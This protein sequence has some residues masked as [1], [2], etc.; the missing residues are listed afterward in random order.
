MLHVTLAS[1]LSLPFWR[2]TAL[3]ISGLLAALAGT[4]YGGLYAIVNYDDVLKPNWS[5]L[6][7][8]AAVIGGVDSTLGSIIGAALIVLANTFFSGTFGAGYNQ[9]AYGVLL[10]LVLLFMPGGLISPFRV[11]INKVLRKLGQNKS[12]PEAYYAGS[13]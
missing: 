12:K 7:I 8:A 1:G 9:I 3:V 2:T 5:I 13:E 11:M 4:I 10:I 6:A